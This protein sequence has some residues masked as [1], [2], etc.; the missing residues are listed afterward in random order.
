MQLNIKETLHEL[1]HHL[2]FTILATF[3]AFIILGLFLSLKIFHSFE[4]LESLFHF[5]HPLHVVVS[6]MTSGAM[7][8]KYK[9]RILPALFVGITG[10][11]IV[12]SLSDIIFPYLGALLLQIEISFHLPLFEEPLIILSSALT[13]SLGGILLKRTKVPHFFHVLISVSA[14]LLYLFA[15]SQ[16]RT[17]LI[18]FLSFIIVL[19]S[20]VIPCCTS[21][22]LFPFLF[23]GKKIKSCDCKTK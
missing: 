20:V 10:A 23:L 8:Y 5:A 13:G 18:F 7:F 1:K 17:L 15:F 12:G 2:P 4:D 11:I 6:A 9:K 19:F 22:I 3:L 14:S 21:D 16:Q